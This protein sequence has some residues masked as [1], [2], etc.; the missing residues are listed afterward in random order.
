M[1]K[2]M[3]LKM[4]C[5]ALCLALLCVPALAETVRLSD[6]VPEAEL[7]VEVVGQQYVGQYDCPVILQITLTAGG[8]QLARVYALGGETWALAEGGLVEVE[9][10]NF[11]GYADLVIATAV[12]AANTTYTFYLWDQEAKEFFW[13]GGPD[14]WNYELAPELNAVISRGTSGYAGLL[15]Q[16]DVY[17]WAGDGRSQELVLTR[18]SL[19]DTVYTESYEDMEN[20]FLVVTH[21]DDSRLIETYTNHLTGEIVT[22][23]YPVARYEEDGDFLSERLGVEEEFLGLD[24]LAPEYDDGSNG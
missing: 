22:A 13:Y 3:L 6:E 21:Y 1:M 2:N 14:L 11:D 12:G 9:D 8:E 15:H 20:G 24:E 18:S 23:E 17:T 19:W 10:V 4:L 7:S 5:A 16:V